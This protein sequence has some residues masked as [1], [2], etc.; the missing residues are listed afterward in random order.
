MKNR[1]IF[2]LLSLVVLAISLS[3]FVSAKRVAEETRRVDSFTKIGL[4]YPATL[5]LRQGG[6]QSL[7]LQGDSDLLAELVTEVKDGQ[8]R[9]RTKEGNWNM[10]WN[11]RERV[12][13]YITVPKIEALA[14]SGSGKITS[15]DTFKGESLDLAVSGSGKIEVSA[16]VEKVSSRISG[17]GSIEL[18]GEGKES[19]VSVSGSGSLR[20]YSFATDNTKVSISGSGNCEVNAKS[21]L[22]TSISGSGR[23]SYDG[24]PSVNSRVSGSGGVK[25]RG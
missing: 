16:K 6:T 23:V 12:T 21:T 11:N 24:S 1:S 10:S 2:S 22:K 14:V 3:S 9:I 18:T 15:E 19:T 5:I 8:L 25:R 17:S 20:G 13:I 7:R 4:G